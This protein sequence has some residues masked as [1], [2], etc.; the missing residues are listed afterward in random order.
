MRLCA[1]YL[2]RQAGGGGHAG[3]DPV[4]RFH[5]GNGAALERLNW[6]GD[7][8]QAGMARSAGLM[9]NYVYRLNEV[10]RN[11]ERYFAAMRSPPR[12]RSRSSRG[13]PARRAGRKGP[14]A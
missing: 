2:V 11:H 13:M 10:E 8:S 3:L 7:T 9:V 4:A 5:L 1:Y 6:M 14:A 12:R